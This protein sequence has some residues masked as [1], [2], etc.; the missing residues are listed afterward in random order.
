MKKSGD[1]LHTNCHTIFYA[2]TVNA[3]ALITTNG[4]NDHHLSI[5]RRTVVKIY[6]LSI[7]IYIFPS[8]DIKFSLYQRFDRHF[9]M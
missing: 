8:T 1:Q 2:I 4:H 7:I 5:I 9:E 6:Q 3:G